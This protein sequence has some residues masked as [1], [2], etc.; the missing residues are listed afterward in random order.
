VKCVQPWAALPFLSRTSGSCHRLH[1]VSGIFIYSTEQRLFWGSRCIKVHSKVNYPT[2][3]M[4]SLPFKNRRTARLSGVAG[5]KGSRKPSRA[6]EMA[7]LWVRS[8][9]CS[10]QGPEFSSHH[11]HQETHGCLWLRLQEDWIPFLSPL[12]PAQ[13]QKAIHRHTDA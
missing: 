13:V 3:Q 12:A 6:G 9:L 1:L 4:S 8:F 11:Q 7:R 2:L 10:R 5:V